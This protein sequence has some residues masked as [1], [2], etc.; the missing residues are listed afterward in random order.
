[1]LNK[2]EMDRINFL[3]KKAK[4]T[5]LSAEE[6]HEQKKLREEYLHY[7]R[8]GMRQHIESLKV[9]DEKGRDV[10]P[11]KLKKIQ[12]DKGIHGR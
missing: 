8:K 11:E 12:K 5:G 3:A 2:E 6:K 9:V 10:T 7:F 1:M 4:T